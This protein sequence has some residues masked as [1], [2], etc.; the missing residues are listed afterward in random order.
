MLRLSEIAF[1][2]KDVLLDSSSPSGSIADLLCPTPADPTPA[3]EPVDETGLPVTSISHMHEEEL[4][5]GQKIA[6]L[7]AVV[8]PLVGLVAAIVLLWGRGVGWLEVSALVGM[9]ALTLF[10][11]TVGFH[12]LFTHK[13]FETVLPVRVFLAIA[14]SMSVEGPVIKWCAVH[15]RHHQCSDHEGDP[16]SPHLHGDSWAGF[17]KGLFH[18]HM[19]WLF[20]PD[21]VDV[22]RSAKDLVNDRALRFVDRTFVLWVILGLILP[23]LVGWAVTQSWWGLLLGFI[24]GG[25]VRVFIAHHVTWSIN[26][27]CH[28]WGRRDYRSNDQSTNNFAIALISGGEGWHNNH[29]AF[30]TSARHGLQWWQIDLSWYLIKLL[31]WFGLA[32]DIRTPS[33]KALAAKK[34][35]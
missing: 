10:G 19:G 33:E 29:H 7:G 14:G 24:W 16:H 8:I 21:V 12:R 18:A 27:V 35:G 20:Q 22:Q 1:V 32:W 13:S 5:L 9:Y 3:A 28:V 34:A 17:F 31:S 2:L 26:S 6:V 11:V 15:R 23:A 4:P 25:L 30:P